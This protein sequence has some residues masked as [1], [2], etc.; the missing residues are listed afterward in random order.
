[1]ASSAR[2]LNAM[3]ISCNTSKI[4]VRLNSHGT[5]MCAHVSG[6]LAAAFR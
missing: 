3:H 2:T 4:F 6:I 1:M 5:V